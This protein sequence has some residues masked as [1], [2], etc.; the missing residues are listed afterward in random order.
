MMRGMIGNWTLM[1]DGMEME[2]LRMDASSAV[3]LLFFDDS[4]PGVKPF[5]IVLCMH[6][7]RM[8]E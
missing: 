6:A 1:D 8:E 4:I 5:V 7:S 2:F 3:F